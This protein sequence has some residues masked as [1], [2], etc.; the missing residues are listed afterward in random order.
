MGR[1]QTSTSAYFVTFQPLAD[2]QVQVLR[3]KKNTLK[4]QLIT[5][6]ELQDH[7]LCLTGIGERFTLPLSQVKCDYDRVNWLHNRYQNHA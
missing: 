5:P 2:G 3:G 6:V 4:D 7:S 1:V